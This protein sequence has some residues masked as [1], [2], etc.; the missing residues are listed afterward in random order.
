MAL[1]GEKDEVDTTEL[2]ETELQ[3]HLQGVNAK[4]QLYREAVTR[5]KACREREQRANNGVEGRC[6][7]TI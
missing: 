3:K 4:E 2:D 7:Y 5:C 6:Y 1:V